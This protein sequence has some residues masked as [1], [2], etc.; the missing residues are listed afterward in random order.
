[1]KRKIL[2]LLIAIAVIFNILNPVW[3]ISNEIKSKE[4]GKNKALNVSE[5]E[6]VYKEDENDLPLVREEMPKEEVKDQYFKIIFSP[7]I[8]YKKGTDLK[9]YGKLINK[10]GEEIELI[11]GSTLTPSGTIKFKGKIFYALK[12]ADWSE[13]LTYKLKDGTCL[14]DISAANNE[15]DPEKKEIH[16]FKS[17]AINGINVDFENPKTIEKRVKKNKCDTEKAVVFH[18]VF[19]NNP[20]I[21]ST[22]F[23]PSRDS[24]NYMIDYKDCYKI[25]FVYNKQDQVPGYGKLNLSDWQKK[26]AIDEIND[27]DEINL[28]LRKDFKNE[29]LSKLQPLIQ[30]D[31]NHKFW[32]WYEIGNFNHKLDENSPIPTEHYINNIAGRFLYDGMLLDSGEG[33]EN[34]PLL[35]GFYKIRFET[36]DGFGFSNFKNGYNNK[37]KNFAIKSGSSLNIIKNLPEKPVLHDKNWKDYSDSVY[38]FLD[39]KKIEDIKNIKVDSD[40]VFVARFEREADKFIPQTKEIEIN[41]NEEVT[42]ERL[43]EGIT[44]LKEDVK[45]VEIKEKAD[46]SKVGKSKAVLILTF[47]DSSNKE[48]EIPVKVIEKIEGSIISPIPKIEEKDIVKEEVPYNG[49]INLLDNINNLP[50]ATKIEDITSPSIDTKVPGTYTGK[51]KV[52][53]KNSSSRIIEIPIVIFKSLADEFT[54]KV[55]NIEV[56]KGQV[57]DS[58]LI[59]NY[60]GNED[61]NIVEV[62]IKNEINTLETGEYKLNLD[63]IFKDGSISE[64]E[65]IIKV[66]EKENPKKSFAE[67][68][69]IIKPEKT[70]VEDKNSLSETEKSEIIKKI[71][72]INP[73]AKSVSMDNMKNV[74]LTYEDGSKNLIS[75]IELVEEIDKIEEEDKNKEEKENKDNHIKDME[76]K[77]IDKLDYYWKNF[78]RRSYRRENRPIY[79]V[80]LVNDFE[81]K[82]N[83]LKKKKYII[84]TKNGS[85]TIIDDEKI[86][87]KFM[88]TKV[89]IKNDRTFIPA[90]S[91]AEIL[92][93]KVIWNENT[94]TASFTRENL[95]AILQIDHNQIILSNGKIFF[96]EEKPLIIDGRI[97]LPLRSIAEVFGMSCGN[98]RDG[99]KKD[100]EWDD[101]N[102]IITIEVK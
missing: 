7:E 18:S 9:Y 51:V 32:Y 50:E 31:E 99:E 38:W 23:G 46:T 15:S 89:F 16:K 21:Y 39:G 58:D 34:K 102:K 48:V 74:I 22:S 44:N 27:L 14:V 28:I 69:P 92:D 33:S 63:L 82:S 80:N 66:K 98:V 81:D 95:T 72:E 49:E 17:W 61:N 94:R 90:R 11:D 91:M 56:I 29:K 97:Y 43:K 10:Y 8:A 54:P 88:T 65:L 53:F 77:N 64:I 52:T 42:V 37:Y 87:N 2:S 36:E 76:E 35:E 24:D 71:L 84:D 86:E 6:N 60:I 3:A 5:N 79:F 20:Y 57:V 26:Y 59:K 30:E 62:V 12:N 75:L 68:Y 47:S 100:I 4:L 41:L 1:M 83:K 19:Y 96:M 13:I 67:L 40:K 70:K 73:E 93:A 78:P 25:R 45:K 85:Y 101:E 55:D